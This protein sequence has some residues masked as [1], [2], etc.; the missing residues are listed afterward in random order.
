[1]RWLRE[2]DAGLSAVRRAARTAIVMPILFAVGAGVI[3]DPEIATFAAFGSFALLLL[4]DFGG[5]I[6]D[7]LLAQVCLVGVGAVL[8]T[9]GTLASRTPWTAV[10]AMAVVAFA[11]LFAGVVS[12]VLASATTSALLSFILPVMLP[13][14]PGSIPGRL[15]GWLLA[16]AVSVIA[17]GILWPA[18]DHEPLRGVA[19]E[20][21]RR[22]AWRLQTEVAHA[23]GGLDDPAVLDGARAEAKASVERVR[24]TFF[25]TPYRPTGLTTSARTV[26][27]LVDELV[28][29]EE[30]MDRAVPGPHR[31][32]TD[33]AV[34]AV[35]SAA[36]SLLDHAA[37]ALEQSAD[38]GRLEAHRQRLAD[39]LGEMERQ[40]T[41]T[42]PVQRVPAARVLAMEP[43]LVDERARDRE[44]GEVRELVSSLEPSFRAQ[45]MSFAVTAIAANVS[46]TR[47]AQERTWWEQLIGRQPAGIAGPLSS[48]QERAEAHLERHSVWLRNSLRGA[49]ALAAAVLVADLT[50]V[51]HSFWV[52][53][54]TL[55]VLRSNALS[56][57]QNAIRA[58]GGTVAG[59]IIGGA[60]V[61]LIGT[62]Q[63]VLWALLPL[64]ILFAGLAPA[65]ISFAAGQAA[66]TITLM[67]LF[68]IIQPTGWS[69]GLVRIED[70]ALGCL[71]SL[72][73]GILFWPSGATS[74]LGRALA[75]AYAESARY[76]RSCVDF[77]MQCCDPGG[78]PPPSP[79]QQ[80]ARSAAAS[81]RLDDAFRGFLAERGTKHLP[82]AKVT[83]L[84]TGVV[85][86]RLTADAVLDLWTGSDGASEQDRAA[87]RIEL[88]HIADRVAVWYEALAR[89]LQGSAPLPDPLPHD[90]AADARF[91]DAVRRNVR[92]ADGYTTAA[93]VRMIWSGDHVDAARRLQ[94]SLAE[95]A[96]AVFKARRRRWSGVVAIPR[97]D[98]AMVG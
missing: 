85:G 6:R 15:G 55:A 79:Q 65:T 23:A 52:V 48:A 54:G 64:A 87:A 39:A 50:G 38:D 13:G 18:P 53:L 47:A 24:T 66:F 8:V 10:P 74:V 17:I 49:L 43:A 35:R 34:C 86:V 37:T 5:R 1:L 94:T 25:A 69:V 32:V 3:R 90:T 77:G 71:V 30:I 36:A 60:L 20:A 46:A 51:Q 11:V 31:H 72:L 27:R 68:N 16:G 62:H 57:G 98:H 28:W 2:R 56:T 61:G 45:E 44:S 9:V 75:E 67:V 58:V 4:A 21:C 7:R 19:A 76:L 41:R 42:L 84:I 14:G 93:A 73:V 29:L 96:R 26:V 22:L 92:D 95:P 40:V 63:T 59:V 81:R 33:P 91:I 78:G 12:S 83:V 88:M 80:S 70:V 82:L 89:T 97:R